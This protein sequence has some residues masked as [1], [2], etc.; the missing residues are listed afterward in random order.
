MCVCACVHFGMRAISASVEKCHL[1]LPSH[2]AI[3]GIDGTPVFTTGSGMLI[4]YDGK[5]QVT[6]FFGGFEGGGDY[7]LIKEDDW[8][9]SFFWQV[10][11]VSSIPGGFSSKWHHWKFKILWTLI[12]AF[13]WCVA[14]LV[15][16]KLVQHKFFVKSGGK[17]KKSLQGVF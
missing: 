13:R 5:W 9:F 4:N 6:R 12:S 11:W 17:K 15:Q 16:Y 2:A 14:L 10:R 3:G 8:S 7:S 1:P